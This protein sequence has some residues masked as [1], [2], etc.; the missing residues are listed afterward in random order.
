MKRTR[1][2]IGLAEV[3]LSFKW[4]QSLLGL[5]CRRD[6]CWNSVTRSPAF[7]EYPVKQR[8]QLADRWALLQASASRRPYAC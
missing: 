3:P 4:Y 1:T 2:I 7:R 5:R 6:L 8:G